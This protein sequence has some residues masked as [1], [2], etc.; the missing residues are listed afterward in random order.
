MK[1]IVFEL[2]TVFYLIIAIFT[3]AFLL[4]YNTYNIAETENKTYYVAKNNNKEYHYG[5][6]IIINHK[7]KDNL[8]KNEYIFYYNTHKKMIVGF[9][10]I[11]AVEKITK[12][13]TTCLLDNDNY[14]SSE[15]VIGSLNNTDIIPVI[16][17]PILLFT[18]TWGYLI[19][20]VLP[21]FCLFIYEI[22]EVA[23]EAKR[24]K[25]EKS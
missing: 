18:S 11:K 1:K 2:L 17:Y 20:I 25:Y 16:G 22:K 21:L 14:I 8:K 23:K 12:N 4:S 10:K 24:K 7:N 13:E 19:F 6:L 3:T 5:D 9:K 15:Y